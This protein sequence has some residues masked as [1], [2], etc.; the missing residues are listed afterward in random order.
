VLCNDKPAAHADHYPM[1]KRELQAK[2]LDEH[3]PMYGRGLCH[4]CHSSET[5]KHQPGGWA[6]APP[7]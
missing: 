5:A 6:A 3:H 7:Y 4:G 1:S 2:G